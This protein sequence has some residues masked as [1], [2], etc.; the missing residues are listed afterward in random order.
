[1]AISFNL[2]YGV[3]C[4]KYPAVQTANIYTKSYINHRRT[5][6]LYL[7]LESINEMITAK[8][9]PNI[10]YRNTNPTENV[11]CY[12]PHLFHVNSIGPQDECDSDDDCDDDKASKCSNSDEDDCDKTKCTPTKKNVK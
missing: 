9:T 5:G 12:E 3:L 1:M 10:V 7:T 11:P 4:L 8:C 6:E 2:T